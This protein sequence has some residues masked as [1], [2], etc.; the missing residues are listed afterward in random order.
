[1]FVVYG[2]TL[3]W[4]A[5]S[6]LIGGGTWAILSLLQSY[7]AVRIFRSV[8]RYRGAE[9]DYIKFYEQGRVDEVPVPERAARAFPWLSLALGMVGIA[10]L[11]FAF[12]ALGGGWSYESRGA[13]QKYGEL[14]LAVAIN[15]AV[16]GLGVSISALSARYRYKGMSIGG[17]VLAALIIA[18]ILMGVAMM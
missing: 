4:A 6:N 10:S 8:G 3:A 16:L 18:V 14:A 7:F 12:V 1:M 9:R 17:L 2:V 13:A 11:L 15:A 5:L